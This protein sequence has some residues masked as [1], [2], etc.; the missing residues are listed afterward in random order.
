MHS[1]GQH[2]ALF[3]QYENIFYL[4]LSYVQGL[5]VLSY[6]ASPH[7]TLSVLFLPSAWQ[8]LAKQTFISFVGAHRVSNLKISGAMTFHPFTRGSLNGHLQRCL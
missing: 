6:C 1:A 3:G 7:V 5:L 8:E 4:F 2:P